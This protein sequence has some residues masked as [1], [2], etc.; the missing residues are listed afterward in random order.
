MMTESMAKL[1]GGQF[2]S[3]SY[4]DV[5]HPKP[6]DTRTG[7]EIAADVIKGAGLSIKKTA[8]KKEPFKVK[9]M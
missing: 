3:K 6:K 7:E 4:E 2:L 8:L 9:E 1:A 5:I